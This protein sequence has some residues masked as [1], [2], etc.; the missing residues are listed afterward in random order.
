MRLALAV[1]ATLLLPAGAAAATLLEEMA[2]TGR[3][4]R[5]LSGMEA[6]GLSDRLTGPGPVTVFAPT[7]EAYAAAA[8]GEPGVDAGAVRRIL[9]TH[10]VEG[11]RY[12]ADNLPRTITAA[13]GDTIT[14]RWSE[15][16]LAARVDGGP[17]WPEAPRIEGGDIRADN[18]IAHPLTGILVPAA[19][20]PPLARGGDAHEGSEALADALGA[21]RRGEG[22]DATLV[23]EDLDVVVRPGPE[24]EATAEVTATVPDGEGARAAAAGRP[25]GEAALEGAAERP[26]REPEADRPGRV[27]ARPADDGRPGRVAEAERP[28]APDDP[29]ADGGMAAVDGPASAPGRGEAP[30]SADRRERATDAAATPLEARE[31]RLAKAGRAPLDG[32]ATA[33]DHGQALTADDGGPPSAEATDEPEGQG[34]DDAPRPVEAAGAAPDGAGADGDGTPLDLAGAIEGWTVTGSQGKAIGEVE[35]V[36]RDV[37]S[38]RVEGVLVRT[39]GFLGLGIGGRVV[40]LAPDEISLRPGEE[41]VIASLTRKEARD[42]EAVE[43]PPRS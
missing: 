20:G 8:T 31:A 27:P 34:P 4:D 29:G 28:A 1:A 42:R 17:P 32:G 23:V 24:G 6:A 30:A 11:E 18:G 19:D 10:I 3:F 36:L 41:E 43:A 9:L 35:T 26:T 14:V 12:L 38:G 37:A 21:E 16:V 33:V 40:R 7:D 39:R 2:E 13:S 15:G 22:P 5:F 25:A